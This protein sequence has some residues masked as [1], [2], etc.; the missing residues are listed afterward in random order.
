M[1]G[2]LNVGKCVWKSEDSF[3]KSILSFTGVVPW[4][5][6]DPLRPPLVCD[7]TFLCITLGLENNKDTNSIQVITKLNMVIDVR[8]TEHVRLQSIAV[9]WVGV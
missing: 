6:F 8:S 3:M 7:V 4:Q 9:L 5:G 2:V 1:E